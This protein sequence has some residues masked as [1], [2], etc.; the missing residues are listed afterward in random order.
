MKSNRKARFDLHYYL[1]L[2]PA[3][4]LFTGFI[5]AP[6]ISSIYYSFTNFDGVNPATMNFIGA[7]N[8]KEMIDSDRVHNAFKN[9]II[10]TVSLMILENIVALV[11]AVLVDQ[12]RW[13]KNFFR[14]VFYL[15]VL[16]SGIVMGFIWTILYN[17]NF[18][19]INQ[20]LTKLGLES[21]AIDWLGDQRYTMIS[22]IVAT[23][24]KGAGYYMIIY[25]AALQGVPQDLGEASRIDGA[26]RWQQFRHVTFPLLAGAVT[27]C[28]TLALINGLK[29]FDQIAVM[30]DGGPGFTSET[31]TYII[32]KVAFAEGRQG[33]G[34][35]LAIGLFA[36]ILITTAIQ[37]FILRKR[38]VQL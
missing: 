6:A 36:L 32:Y 22:I 10:L 15:P 18:G 34:T 7:A 35:A 33:F 24:W 25:L 4:L 30:T 27:V 13:F 20:I 8:Y 37:T 26:N 3:F 5:V 17:F 19:A 14:S 9:T 29:V 28:M 38:E 31:M 2:L 23:V 11:L 21:W 1:F 16:I 12:V